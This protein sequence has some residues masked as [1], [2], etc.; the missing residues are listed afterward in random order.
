[1]SWIFPSRGSSLDEIQLYF[2]AVVS[3]IADER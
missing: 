2:R 1:L 3:Y